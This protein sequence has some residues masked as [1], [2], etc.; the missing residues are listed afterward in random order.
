MG[1]SKCQIDNLISLIDGY[2]VMKGQHL[3][4]NVL[5]KEQLLDVQNHPGKYPN[6]ITVR[7]SGYAVKFNSLTKDQQDDVINRTFHERM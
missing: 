2:F 6:S 7:I 3:N 1:I 5:T 4:V